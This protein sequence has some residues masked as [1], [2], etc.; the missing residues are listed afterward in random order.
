MYCIEIKSHH[1][2]GVVAVELYDT[3]TDGVSGLAVKA[4]KLWR[5]LSQYRPCQVHLRGHDYLLQRPTRA[6]GWPVS[7]FVG[8]MQSQ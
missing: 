4:S 6:S 7:N 2:S 8:S 1:A 3:D 5:L